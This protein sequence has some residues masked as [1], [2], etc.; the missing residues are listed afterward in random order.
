LVADPSDEDDDEVGVEEAVDG[1]EAGVGVES[2]DE[3][4]LGVVDAVEPAPLR[5]SVR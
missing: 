4:E 1:V 5:L 3:D 2:A